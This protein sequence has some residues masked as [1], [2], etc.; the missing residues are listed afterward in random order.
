MNQITWIG[1]P[2]YLPMNL[3]KPLPLPPSGFPT[4]NSK[5]IY[6]VVMLK[7]IFEFMYSCKRYLNAAT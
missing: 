2:E 7:G 1:V 4:I 5:E 3:A 6:L